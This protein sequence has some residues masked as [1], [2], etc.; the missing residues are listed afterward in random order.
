MS[1]KCN[2]VLLNA[3]QFTLVCGQ[4]KVRWCLIRSGEI[5]HPLKC[6][7]QGDMLFLTTASAD[8]RSPQV[9][10]EDEHSTLRV[11]DVYALDV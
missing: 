2:L 8:N 4:I 5:R 9:S 3:N 6:W 1:C 11:N 7:N 10:T